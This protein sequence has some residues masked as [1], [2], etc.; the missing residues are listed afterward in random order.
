MESELPT[1]FGAGGEAAP[2]PAHKDEDD[3]R[4]DYSESNY[5]EFSGYGGSLFDSSV[6]YEKDDEEADK[7]WMT[8]DDKMDSRRRE[9]REQRLKME[10]EKFR[11]E[12]P[13]IQ[14]Q[15]ADLK[16]NL[17]V[18]SAEEWEAI[19]DIGDRSLR[20]KAK[21]VERYTPAPD[22][23]LDRARSESANTTN[24]IGP[25]LDTP[26][27]GMTPYSSSATPIHQDLTAI[28]SARTTMIN[29]RL[30]EASDSVTGQTVV[31][32]KNYLTDL[33]R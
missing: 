25:G 14:Q 9:R 33:R 6:P 22:S 29:M 26:L 13:K 1:Q 10:M 30:K 31:D 8:V 11:A 19:P 21:K 23:L 24:V 3:D 32:P 4:E 16:R 17:S 12:R 7:V 18:V 2:P 27:G 5:D 20:Y 28:G 15:F